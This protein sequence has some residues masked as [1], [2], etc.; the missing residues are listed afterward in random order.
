MK[1]SNDKKDL[2][3]TL[4]GS[5]K[6]FAVSVFIFFIL[7]TV[8]AIVITKIDVSDA[9]IQVMTLASLG[10]ASFVSA[11]LNQKKTRQRGIVIG[12]I[13]SAEIFLVIFIAGLFGNNGA[14]NILMLK[15][16]IVILFAGLLGGILSA[17]SKK[18][19]K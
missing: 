9:T 8:F 14:F 2:A 10:I 6:G 7:I 12:A 5:I 4:K 1:A 15:K 11:Y 17:N 16:S 3:T 13:S 19:Y 18:K